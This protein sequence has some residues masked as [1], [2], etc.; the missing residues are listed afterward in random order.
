MSPLNELLFLS[1][2]ALMSGINDQEPTIIFGEEKLNQLRKYFPYK[3]D[4]SSID[5]LERLYPALDPVSF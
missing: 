2:Y 5:T 3:N 4:I 1:I